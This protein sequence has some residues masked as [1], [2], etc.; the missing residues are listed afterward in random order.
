MM[1]DQKSSLRLIN[2]LDNDLVK[3]IC[4]GEA[5]HRPLNVVKELIENSLDAGS[6]MI[7]VT[8]KDGGLDQ[9]QIQDNGCGINKED[10]KIVCDRFTTSKLKSL[11]DF[12]SLSTFGFRGEALASIAV[13]AQ[14][15]IISKTADSICAYK[16]EYVDG[17]LKNSSAPIVPI[18]ANDGTMI[19]VDNLF[20][21]MPTRKAA[22]SSENQ[23]YNFVQDLIVRY[24][25]IF[26]GKCG[27]IFK[28]YNENS[29]V[30]NTK[31]SATL[32]QNIDQIFGK[33]ISSNLLSFDIENEKL[34]FK[35][36]GYFTKQNISLKQFT[37]ILAIN[38]RLVECETLKKSIKD[39]Y[40]EFLMTDG[41]PFVI[42][43]IEIN[44]KN[45]DV[46][47]HPNKNEV[48][49]LHDDEIISKIIEFIREKLENKLDN[50]MIKNTS[51]TNMDISFIRNQTND[52]K[53]IDNE[54]SAGT[55]K[56]STLKLKLSDAAKQTNSPS[57]TIDNYQ[58]SSQ[59]L[60]VDEKCEDVP[61]KEIETLPR[62]ASKPKSSNPNRICRIDSTIQRIQS[63]L[64]QEVS[65]LGPRRRRRIE[66]TSLDKL[67]KDLS[68]TIDLNL[69]EMLNESIYVGCLDENFLLIQ[70]ELDLIMLNM[71]KLN[72]E[73]F[74]QIY[75]MG[76]V[77]AP[78]MDPD[79]STATIETMVKTI[80]C[81]KE[82]L[83]D[84]FSIRINKDDATIESLPVMIA[85]YEPNYIYLPE[86]IHGLAT[87]IDWNHEKECFGTLGQELAKFYS[88]APSISNTNDAEF[89]VWSD[90]VETQ[91]YPRYKKLLSPTNQLSDGAIYVI[92]N[93]TELYKVFERC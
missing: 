9:I 5:I 49:F 85:K 90:L 28:K 26:S 61:V 16:A 51:S 64:Q 52:K 14:V 47:I 7:T 42:I 27:F 87:N 59:T 2:K 92:A 60:P 71:P 70:H 23:E 76:F 40:K 45:I 12:N 80:V 55:S 4:A 3:K 58:K 19:Q 46:N 75:L 69:V 62:P 78:D 67:M 57:Q 50:D 34:E 25:L 54:N 74:Y 77:N 30:V 21:N 35:I 66:L 38:S 6:T 24:S 8:L 17:H 32:F 43:W 53:P 29:H 20:Y 72:R 89:R 86:F 73:L 13:A 83:D 68:S 31:S 1:A 88:Y 36:H 33:K 81:K 63:Y 84:Y 93:V 82:M 37:F 15:T 79:V 48:C 65:E 56:I 44:P 10:L 39:L 41:H 18:A 91:I 11:D 22:L